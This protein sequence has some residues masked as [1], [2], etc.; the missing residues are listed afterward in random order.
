[1]G[2]GFASASLVTAATAIPLSGIPLSILFG[3]AVGNTL[4]LPPSVK[5]GLTFA[6][7]TVL[8]TGIVCVAAKLSFT[9]LL[10]TG[11]TGI[12]VVLSSVTAGMLFIPWFGRQLGVDRPTSLLLTA[13]TSI[14][15][16]TA[17][18]ALAPSI[19][20]P[21]RAVAVAVGNT[22]A[23]GTMG[24][25]LY[26]YL[27]HEICLTSSHVG[28]SLGTGIHDTSQVLGAAASYDQVRADKNCRP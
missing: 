7:K 22:V 15:G 17:I 10:S 24:M 8:Q 21:P 12:P 5:P 25:L 16:V 19:N 3:L 2:V 20:A 27:A 23:F 9:E 26:P 1:M 18:T 6:T 28:M 4:T 13:G 14:C 11:A